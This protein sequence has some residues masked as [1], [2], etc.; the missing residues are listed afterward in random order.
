MLVTPNTRYPFSST[1]SPISSSILK[2]SA[3]LPFLLAFLHKV[4]RVALVAPVA[5]TA[6]LSINGTS[7]ADKRADNL[8]VPDSVRPSP[9]PD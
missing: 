9:S 4:G 1:T 2:R 5:S 3:Q 8:A 7:L 6:V